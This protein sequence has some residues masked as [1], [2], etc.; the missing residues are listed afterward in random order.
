MPGAG[1]DLAARVGCLFRSRCHRIGPVARH[2][3]LSPAACVHLLKRVLFR[4]RQM[5][6]RVLTK[7]VSGAAFSFYSADEVRALSVK[8]VTNALAFDQ[9]KQPV[10]NGLYDPALGPVDK[11][12]RCA[13]VC[14]DSPGSDSLHP[15]H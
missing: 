12:G 11:F 7:H 6:T 13:H 9:L 8:R 2:S 15:L 5:D 4:Q 3:P 14:A 10:P 1:G